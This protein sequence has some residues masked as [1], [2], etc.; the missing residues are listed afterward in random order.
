MI[1]WAGWWIDLAPLLRAPFRPLILIWR[2][3]VWMN[4]RGPIVRTRFAAPIDRSDPEWQAKWIKLR[5]WFIL[6]CERELGRDL[7]C[8][9]CDAKFPPGMRHKMDVDH[10]V[11]VAVDPSRSL[12]PRNVQILC[13]SCNSAKRDAKG[14]ADYRPQCIII[15]VDFNAQKILE[16]LAA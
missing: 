1:D 13:E 12:D 5:S 15:A 6:L 2:V 14:Q 16:R 8:M 4:D 10:I 7:A 9:Q 11:P 3:V